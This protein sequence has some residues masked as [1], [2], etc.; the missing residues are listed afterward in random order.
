MREIGVVA[1]ALLVLARPVAEDSSIMFI[2][3][4][5][6]LSDVRSTA[7]RLPGVSVKDYIDN[8]TAVVTVLR[9][10]KPLRA[11]LHKG[12]VDIWYVVEGGGTLVTGGSLAGPITS[13]PN[14]VKWQPRSTTPNEL[15]APSISGGDERHISKGDLVVIPP[16]VP[17]WVSKVD[18]EIVYL[19]VK[20]PPGK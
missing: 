9:R 7:E 16:D 5:Q 15:R 10:T 19:V 11:E 20:V 1:A 13:L 2:H 18:G 4:K 12:A 8:S 14:D 6:L 3:A 17:H